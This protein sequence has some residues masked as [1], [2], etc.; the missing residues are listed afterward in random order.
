MVCSIPSLASSRARWICTTA[1]VMEGPIEKDESPSHSSG[2]KEQ[3]P[4]IP[5]HFV[6]RLNGGRQSSSQVSNSTRGGHMAVEIPVLRSVFDP[7]RLKEH[8]EDD[9]CEGCKKM[10]ETRTMT[11][12][13]ESL[14]T[15]DSD[16]EFKVSSIRSHSLPFHEFHTLGCP[17]T[18]TR[19]APFLSPVFLG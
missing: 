8:D 13:L 9:G 4:N 19:Q 7:W 11:S 15:L 2:P 6:W 17:S 3:P 5:R 18:K 14:L 12:S 1:L 10:D 16:S